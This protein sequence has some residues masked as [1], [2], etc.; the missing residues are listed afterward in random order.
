MQH[1][2][3]TSIARATF[4]PEDEEPSLKPLGSL[5]VVLT[6]AS[7]GIGRATALAFAA[8]GASLVLASRH[9][10][11]L[12]EVAQACKAKG[13]TATVVSTDVTDA[14]AVLSLAE[15]AIACLGHVD[16]WI[17]NV[18][19]GAVGLF[20]ETPMEAHRRVIEANLLGHMHGAYAILPH[21][22]SRSS[23]TLVNMISL[24][25]W[26]PAPYATA[27]TA[28][29][30]GL[31]GFSEALRAELSGQPHIHVCEVYP[32]F[33]DTPGMSHG[34]NYS[35]TQVRPPPP[36]V[37]PRTVANAL[38][39]LATR[40]RP[41]TYIGAPARPGI[42]AHALAPNLVVRS[43]KWLTEKSMQRAR[44]AARTEGNL[45]MPSLGTAIDGG[46][47]STPAL[48]PAAVAFGAAAAGFGALMLAGA[49]ARQHRRSA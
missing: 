15:S 38:V 22:R 18:G 30:F 36:V 6:G 16:L 11:H 19:V 8:K 12:Q 46:F 20:D 39:S 29:K 25:G 31:R 49:W 48:N 33:V 1:H 14:K 44:P 47:R 23:G 7:S 37:D 13:G 17:N 24:G 34:A 43:M 32:T 40:P 35:G 45:F 26:V 3:A 42:L 41:S 21:F 27:Y 2:D 9:R 5:N 28:S 10:E 4:E